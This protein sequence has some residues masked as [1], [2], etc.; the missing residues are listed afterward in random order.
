MIIDFVMLI[1]LN[2]Q[3]NWKI[4]FNENYVWELLELFIIGKGFIVG[5]GDYIN[6]IEDDICEIV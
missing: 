3:D 6:Y 2:G 1:Y 5:F 4:F